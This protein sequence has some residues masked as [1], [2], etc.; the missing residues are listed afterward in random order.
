[1]FKTHNVAPGIGDSRGTFSWLCIAIACFN[2]T[3]RGHVLLI[4][5]HT[6]L[7]VHVPSVEPQKPQG[8]ASPWI[9]GSGT[10]SPLCKCT[11]TMSPHPSYSDGESTKQTNFVACAGCTLIS[12]S[13]AYGSA[14]N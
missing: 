2:G 8:S 6:M 4:F 14:H 3:K 5:L 13:P 10:T 1:M 7:V 11:V 12:A 9:L